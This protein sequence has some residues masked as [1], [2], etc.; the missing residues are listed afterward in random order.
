MVTERRERYVNGEGVSSIARSE[1]VSR[2]A[3][4]IHLKRFADWQ[5]M[6]DEHNINKAKRRRRA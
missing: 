6:R 2:Q 4:H 3:V 1:G 5:D